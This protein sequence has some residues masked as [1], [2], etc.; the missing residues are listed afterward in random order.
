[1]KEELMNSGAARWALVHLDGWTWLV[2]EYRVWL[3][4][5]ATVAGLAAPFLGAA[6]KHL[7][8]PAPSLIIHRGALALAFSAAMVTICSLLH[9]SDLRWLAPSQRTAVHVSAPSGFLGFAKPIVAA[10]NSV[11]AV[12]VEFRAT[13]VSVHTAI[14]CAFLALA[15]FFLVAI[16]WRRARRADIRQIVQEEIRRSAGAYARGS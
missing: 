8:R 11:A 9:F 16:T 1:V 15:A 7:P 3:I 14:I 12:P 5:A 13:Q 10:V 6:R 4:T 2:A